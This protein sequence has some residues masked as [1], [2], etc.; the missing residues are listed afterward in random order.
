MVLILKHV[1]EIVVESVSVAIAGTECLF[2]LVGRC[3]LHRR[4]IGD[5][6]GCQA[7]ETVVTL[8]I[9]FQATLNLE[10]ETLGDVPVESGVGIPCRADPLGIIVRDRF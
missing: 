9:V 10:T 8:T 2:V 7:I 5:I 1:G 3:V 6:V 4:V